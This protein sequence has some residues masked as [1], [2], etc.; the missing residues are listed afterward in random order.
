VRHRLLLVG[1][2]V[3][4]DG[5]AACW[6]TQPQ[7]RYKSSP[8]NLHISLHGATLDSLTDFR[9]GLAEAIEAA[10]K[11]GPATPDAD[12]LA[13]VAGLDPS[14][15]TPDEYTAIL[16]DAD[17]GGN[18]RLPQRMA[19]VNHLLNAAA[20]ALREQLLL[21][22]LDVLYVPTRSTAADH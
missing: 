18:G 2:A 4:H 21:S 11:A 14:T 20:L 3:D 15:L 10:L 6:F 1:A 5:S 13:L 22:F 8:A 16:A 19:T 7:F 17:L 9:A 12:T